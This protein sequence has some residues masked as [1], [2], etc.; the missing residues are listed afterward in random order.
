MGSRRTTVVNETRVTRTAVIAPP[1]LPPVQPVVQSGKVSGTPTVYTISAVRRIQPAPDLP[2]FFG[3]RYNPFR[4]AYNTV[5]Y[6]PYR[7]RTVYNPPIQPYTPPQAVAN[8]DLI[9]AG[10]TKDEVCD[11][12]LQN[13][14]RS[15]DNFNITGNGKATRFRFPV[16]GAPTEVAVTN[17]STGSTVSSSDYT[18]LVR[19]KSVS[20]IIFDTAPA[21]GVSYNIKYIIGDN[22]FIR[23][24]KAG[25]WTGWLLKLN[26]LHRQLES[27]RNNAQSR[28]SYNTGYR[29]TQNTIPES[30]QYDVAIEA[31]I[32]LKKTIQRPGIK[33]DTRNIATACNN[34]DAQLEKIN[35][36]TGKNSQADAT[37]GAPLV[38]SP[39]IS[40][41][42]NIVFEFDQR[43]DG[44]KKSS[45]CNG[46]YLND[47]RKTY[48]L[49]FD[50]QVKANYFDTN[51]GVYC[52]PPPPVFTPGVYSSDNDDSPKWKGKGPK[53]SAPIKGPS[54]KVDSSGNKSFA[55]KNSNSGGKS[56][57]GGGG[58]RGGS[59]DFGSVDSS[60]E[61]GTGPF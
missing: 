20:W 55:T 10:Q 56:S 38:S 6:V 44:F 3:Q 26:T 12:I 50:N 57:G 27:A 52:P 48:N 40:R 31:V 25:D 58:G 59:S 5:P 51:A 14:V 16:A 33:L 23:T 30:S 53:V 8:T 28:Q 34:L 45:D 37:V 39:N 24:V 61:K 19:D 17:N 2:L 15:V 29:T 54:V 4:T 42:A 46:Y 11:D 36:G 43:Y 13:P 41:P 47:Q 35:A 21:D 1:T 7:P 9:S 22:P 18:V 60:R 32:E 49:Q